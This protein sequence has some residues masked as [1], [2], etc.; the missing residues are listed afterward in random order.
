M[1]RLIK[2]QR[3]DTKRGGRSVRNFTILYF[4]AGEADHEEAEKGDCEV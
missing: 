4:Q 3:K 2:R 1:L